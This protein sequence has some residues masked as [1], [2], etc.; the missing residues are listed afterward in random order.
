MTSIRPR[1]VLIAATVVAL[2]AGLFGGGADAEVVV[3][4]IEGKPLDEVRPAPGFF[5]PD[6]D[7]ITANHLLPK[8]TLPSWDRSC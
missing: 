2:A 3:R 7:V 8:S 6:L 4:G 1:H 5:K